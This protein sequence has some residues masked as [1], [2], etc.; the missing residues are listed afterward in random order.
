[1]MP[2]QHAEHAALGA[3]RH[4]S[5]RRRLGVEAAVAGPFLGVEHR[6][7]ALEPEDAAVDVRL[8]QQH[9]GVVHQVAGRE[10]VGPVDDDVVV[11]DDLER[12][13]GREPGL[14]PDRRS[15]SGLRSVSRALAD[16]SLGRPSV[17][18]PCTICRCRLVRSTTSKSTMPIVPT[19]GRRQVER[20]RRAEPAG[21]DRQH[22][23]RLELPLA[24]DARPRAG[25]GGA[26]TAAPRRATAWAARSRCAGL[27]PG[28]AGHDREHVARGAPAW[29]WTSSCRM[30]VSLRYRFTKFRS[31]PS[32][33]TRWRLRPVC[34][35]SSSSSTSPTVPPATLDGVAPA[36]EAAQRSRNGDGHGHRHTSLRTSSDSGC[37]SGPRRRPAPSWPA[38]APRPRSI[39]TIR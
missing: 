10:V 20:Q 1:M 7:L 31:R 14:V 2:G 26:S 12:V 5:R 3:A 28:D 4:Q 15:R 33:C 16:S 13:L 32:S 11:P 36:G 39:R 35:A 37:I 21:A 17:D 34:A 29:R 27:P 22:P 23:R 9:A 8:A 18:V 19:P 25:A 30:S 24:L 6:R 38:S